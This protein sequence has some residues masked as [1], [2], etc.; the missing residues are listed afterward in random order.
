MP[1]LFCCIFSNISL[2]YTATF[3]LRESRSGRERRTV[4]MYTLLWVCNERER[5]EKGEE[6]RRGGDIR[7][8][9]NVLLIRKGEGRGKDRKAK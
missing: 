1:I 7:E 2:Y 5:K 4:D 6:G 3:T 8:T 9:N